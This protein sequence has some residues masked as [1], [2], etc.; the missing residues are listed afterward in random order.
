MKEQP[1]VGGGRVDIDI[2][3]VTKANAK[4]L[5]ER[6][7]VNPK[8]TQATEQIVNKLM[9]LTMENLSKEDV[10]LQ[11][12]GFTSVQCRKR[13]AAEAA[14][15]LQHLRT[16]ADGKV[17]AALN[18]SQLAHSECGWIYMMASVCHE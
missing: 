7:T 16:I 18:G 1:Q 4:A 8:A 17:G 15:S 14:V 3:D 13:A 6:A 11:K 12:L 10:F 5:K 2:G 9:T